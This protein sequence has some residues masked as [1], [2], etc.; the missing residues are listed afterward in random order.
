MSV[1]KC[2]KKTEHPTKVSTDVR[3]SEA[4]D[5]LAREGVRSRY[6]EI[7]QTGLHKES[8]WH[9]RCYYKNEETRRLSDRDSIG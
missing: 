6:Y 9:K 7:I 5:T 1:R 3:R 4:R 2:D 8:G